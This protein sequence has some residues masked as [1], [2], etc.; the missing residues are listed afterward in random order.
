MVKLSSGPVA[1]RLANKVAFVTGTGGGQGRAVALMFAR[2][3]ALVLGC[4]HNEQMNMETTEIARHENLTVISTKL[5]CSDP[6]LARRW[7]DDGV[8]KF[9]KLDILYNNAGFAH[10]APVDHMTPTQWSETLRYELDIVF[11]PTQAAWPHLV[12][13]GGGSV[14][15]V[16][17]VS[18]MRAT[19]RLPAVAHATGKGGVIAFTKQISLEGAP[20]QIRVNSISPGPILTPVTKAALEADPSFRA[21]FESWPRLGR[22]GHPE[23]IAYSALFLASDESAW[24]TGVN[25]VVDGG[26]TA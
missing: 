25:L 7:I 15:N 1:G 11:Y 3:G 10:F 4:D 9:G 21:T 22:V 2:A 24:I 14:V 13:N 12:A 18:G 23:D 16:A 8:A 17:S 5:D 6:D 26:W 19:E 20:H